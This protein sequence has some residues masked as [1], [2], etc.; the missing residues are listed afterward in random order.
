MWPEYYGG[1]FHESTQ[2]RQETRAQDIANHK[3]KKGKERKNWEN[4][5]TIWQGKKRFR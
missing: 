1:I 2:E 4:R 3:G 5:N